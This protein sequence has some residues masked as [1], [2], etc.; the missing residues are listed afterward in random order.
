MCIKVVITVLLSL[1]F[2]S[3]SHSEQGY[4]FSPSNDD[5]FEMTAS[6]SVPMSL[7]SS[8]SGS[9]KTKPKSNKTSVHAHTCGYDISDSLMYRACRHSRP[10]SCMKLL[11]H[12]ILLEKILI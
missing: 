2:S 6:V 11:R 3:M 9:D 5:L 10:L 12:L 1:C 4:T 8:L 7:S